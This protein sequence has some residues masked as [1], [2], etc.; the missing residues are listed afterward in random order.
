M[1]H[2]NGQTAQGLWNRIV[3]NPALWRTSCVSVDRVLSKK[4]VVVMP[5][6]TVLKIK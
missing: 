1:E 2:P 6:I 3:L 4:W 5:S